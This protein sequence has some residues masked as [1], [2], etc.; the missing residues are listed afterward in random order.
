[1]LLNPTPK[2]APDYASEL[3]RLTSEGWVVQSDGPSGAQLIGPK[4]MRKA[5]QAAAILG[6]ALIIFFWALGLILI[7]AAAIDYLAF[8]KP[9]TKFLARPATA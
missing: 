5:D 1:M 2:S 9:P 4:K 6:A 3:S 7:V 8:T